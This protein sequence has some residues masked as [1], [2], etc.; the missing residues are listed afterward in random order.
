VFT[1]GSVVINVTH[2]SSFTLLRRQLHR[3]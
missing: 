3:Y 1:V 2:P